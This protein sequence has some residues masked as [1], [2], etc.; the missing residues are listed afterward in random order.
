[1]YMTAAPLLLL[2]GVGIG[3]RALQSCNHNE[4]EILW[5][6]SNSIIVF[7]LYMTAVPLDRLYVQATPFNIKKCCMAHYCFVK[8]AE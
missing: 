7:Y 8:R 3:S 1:M 6:E 2:D 5:K 4:E